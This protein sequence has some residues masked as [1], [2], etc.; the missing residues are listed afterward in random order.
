MIRFQPDTLLQACTRF[1]DM[2]APD[3]NVYI[4]V[5]APDLRMGALLLLAGAALV[6]WRRL[7]AGRGPVAAMFVLLLASATIWLWTSGNGRYFLPMLV[8]AGPIAI[9]LLCLLPVARRWK[10]MLGIGLAVAQVFVLTQQPPWH[11]WAW[12]DWKEAPYFAVELG[13]AQKN[14]PPTTYATLSSISYSLIAPQFPAN[15]RWISVATGGITPRDDAWSDAFLRRAATE[16]PM[17]LLVPSLP[18][19]SLDTGLPNPDALAAFDKLIASRNL[20]ITGTCELIPS[21]AQ[22]RL[23]GLEEAVRAGRSR[24]VGFW[25]CPMAYEQRAVEPARRLTPPEAVQRSFEELAKIC[26]RFFPKDDGSTMRVVDG[27]E[28][29]YGSETRVYVLDNGQVWYK[30]WRS[31]NPVLIGQV[32]DVV[33]GQVVIDCTAIRGSDRPWQTGAQ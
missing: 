21:R 1:F 32:P 2:A 14:A 20:R 26:P 6:L 11:S 4:E 7:G 15:A 22:A 25:S 24:P 19:I 12:L 3:A 30:F 23:E 29:R 16:G 17:R 10:A 31:L 5:A 9:G 13:P 28:R 18:S 27:W 33:A 8:C